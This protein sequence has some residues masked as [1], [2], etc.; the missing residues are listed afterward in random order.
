MQLHPA[1]VLVATPPTYQ[2]QLLDTGRTLAGLVQPTLNGSLVAGQ[3][4]ILGVG[5]RVIVAYW[6]DATPFILCGLSAWR[7]QLASVPT[8]LPHEQY[9]YGPTGSVLKMIT[10]GAVEIG[11]PAGT[12]KA[13]ALNGD[14]VSVSGNVPSGGGNVTL[15][16]TVTASS[17]V[18]KG[19]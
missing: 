18:L 16:G 17:A 7:D 11:A 3:F 13:V 4:G 2:V 9:L 6:A 5:D 19:N 15:T 1:K 12:F 10:S 8:G 14:S